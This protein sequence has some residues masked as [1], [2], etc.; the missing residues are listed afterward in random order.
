VAEVGRIA[1][2]GAGAFAYEI[3]YA[4]V[5]A[6]YSVT[7]HDMGEGPADAGTGAVRERL[8][9]CEENGLITREESRVMMSRL[10]PARDLRSAASG[11]DLV[12]EAILEGLGLKKKLFAFLDRCC[13]SHSILAG[14]ASS[15]KIPALAEASLRPGK[16]V[17][18]HFL[19]PPETRLV[20]VVLGDRSSDEAVAAA[21]AVATGMGK[22]PVVVP[23]DSTGL[24]FNRVNE[25]TKLMEE[26]V[27][28]DPE[29]IDA[30]VADGR[31]G[32]ALFP[33]AKGIGCPTLAERCNGLSRTSGIE[34]FR[35]T[36]TMKGLH[37]DTRV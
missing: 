7:L 21:C 1:V 13:P 11:A 19:D 36:E 28:E 16:V 9:R 30:A 26:R 37:V 33:L 25:A 17:G 15:V 5:M 10:T 20:E 35:P 24:I 32:V 14:S 34:A 2:I 4:G 31:S 3:A 12:I 23:R 6:G 18:M 27:V 22:V 29:I 8:R